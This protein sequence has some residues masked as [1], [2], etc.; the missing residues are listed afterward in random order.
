MST[1]ASLATLL[2]IDSDINFYTLQMTH[3][4]NLHKRTTE[5]VAAYQK[6]EEI[7]N[8]AYDKAFNLDDGKTLEVNGVTITGGNVT[9]EMAHMYA[10]LKTDIDYTQ[11]E[12]DLEEVSSW[13][14]YYECEESTN[15]AVL[16]QLRA[17]KQNVQQL[18]ST[19]A[20]DTH[21]SGS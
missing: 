19:N 7:Y 3:F 8:K 16:E 21:Q 4:Q 12:I 15:N 5:E 11:L 10:A 18:V 9:E 14:T 1:A 13:D 2:Q 20:Q 6:K 17:Q